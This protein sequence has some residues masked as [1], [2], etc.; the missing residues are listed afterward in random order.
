[1]TLRVVLLTTVLTFV[2]SM[3]ACAHSTGRRLLPTESPKHLVV[4]GS[5]EEGIIEI[6]LGQLFKPGNTSYAAMDRK[7][8]KD[9][10]P[11][12]TGF[13]PY[14]DQAYTVT[15]EALVSGEHTIVFQFPSVNNQAEFNRLEI[16][17]LEE[18]ELSPFGQSWIPVTVVA[19][20]WDKDAFKF[21]S[22]AAY[23]Q[24]LPDFSSHR[25]A[26]IAAGFGTFAIAIAPE[27]YDVPKEA[28]TR[29]EMLP[30]SGPETA[31]KREQVTHT[32]V[33]KNNGPIKA[34][35]VNFREVIGSQ[36]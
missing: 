36:H 21:I 9:V 17:H 10:P 25:V 3:A 4:E 8:L 18:D 28:F 7:T 11:L 32:F 24:L 1:V 6:T 20:G 5:Q 16:L 19:N 29:M 35:D 13:V 30:T 12:P 26:A 23:E 22:K 27:S 15:T 14:R 33:I 34:E 2:C 31:R